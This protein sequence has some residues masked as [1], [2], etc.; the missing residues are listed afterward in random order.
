MS[1]LLNPKGQNANDSTFKN[2]ENVIQTFVDARCYI[3]KM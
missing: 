2:E 3:D 1:D